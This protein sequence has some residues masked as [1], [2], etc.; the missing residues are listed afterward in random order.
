MKKSVFII[1]TV[2]ICGVLYAQSTPRIAV[3]PFEAVGVSENDALVAY[4]LFETAL[5]QT[6]KFTILEQNQ[7][8]D[9]LD[10]QEYSLSGCTD[11][12]CAVEIGKLLS[13][14]QIF[15]G[16]LFHIGDDYIITIKLVDIALGKHIKAE[17][18]TFKSTS[19]LSNTAD[20]IAAKFVEPSEE[21]KNQIKRRESFI[22]YD[23][24][25][26]ELEE[27]MKLVTIMQIGQFENKVNTFNAEL[28]Q[29]DFTFPMLEERA[30][31]L[32][33]NIRKKQISIENSSKISR[34]KNQLIILEAEHE[35]AL[36]KDRRRGGARVLFGIL[37]L[38]SFGGQVIA[39]IKETRFTRTTIKL[40]LPYQQRSC[41]M[42]QNSTRY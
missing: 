24:R 9:I 41:V 1:F 12:T 7:V 14:E 11:E 28:A 16:S 10:A 29:I 40:K 27:E 15:L 30:Q 17:K 38:G 21:E 42:K 23:N 19:D 4:R 22:E 34:L 8:E 37:S 5:V 33:D 32:I 2:L 6:D 3:L 36:A 35:E 18:I 20:S 25:L 13:A 39:G 26:T 31:V